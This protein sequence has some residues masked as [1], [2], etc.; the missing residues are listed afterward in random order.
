MYLIFYK[1]A[2]DKRNLLEKMNFSL[3]FDGIISFYDFYQY[4]LTHYDSTSFGNYLFSMFLVVPLQQCY[5]FRYKQLFYSDY[6]HLFKF[7]KFDTPQT[8][9]LIPMKNFLQPNEKSLHLIR[10]YSQLLLD[11]SEFDMIANSKFAYTL[12]ISHL[13]SFIFE[14][15][16]RLERKVEF[17]FKK[18]LVTHF[19]SL[20]NMVISS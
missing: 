18:L 9:L 4:L 6:S 15:T 20:Q 7:I 11:K 1:Y 14:H 19:L 3:K 2:N 12:I 13:N 8:K 17:D 10:L 16:N 5:P